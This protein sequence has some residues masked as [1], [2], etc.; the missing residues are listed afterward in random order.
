MSV[1]LPNGH[2]TEDTA[3]RTAHDWGRAQ[4]RPPRSATVSRKSYTVS[5]KLYYGRAIAC[6]I[7][8]MV[9]ACDGPTSTSSSSDPSS[10]PV[11]GMGA[12]TDESVRTEA[13]GVAYPFV[14]LEPTATATLSVGQQATFW[15]HLSE[16]NGNNWPS[17]CSTWV[18][19]DPS[20]AS[21]SVIGYGLLSGEHAVVVAHSRGRAT[22][23]ATTESQTTGTLTVT[24]GSA[25]GTSTSEGSTSGYTSSGSSS[26][27]GSKSVA[28][29]SASEPT[30]GT[31]EPA[32]MATQVNTGAL[33]STA[34]FS[35][36][37]SSSQSS[38]GAWSGNLTP[39]PGGTGLR[40]T[41]RTNLPAGSAPVTFGVGIRSPGTGWYYQRMNVRFSPNWT[42]AENPVIKL[43]EPQTQQHGSG[44]GPTENPVIGGFVN[45]GPTESYLTTLLQGPNGH[46]RDLFAEPT[47]NAQAN[48]SDGNWHTMEVLFGPESSPGAGNGTYKAWVD[49]VQ[50]ASDDNVLWL[51]PGNRVGWPYLL[52]QPVYGGVQSRPP[53]T[54]YWDFDELYVSTR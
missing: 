1:R 12:R 31:H 18:S 51:A 5:R 30:T 50:V 16:A 21:V 2:L 47:P 28:S 46:F 7:V 37:S 43:C 45:A 35:M 20:I 27:S 42:N 23:T 6:V 48:L 17:C 4:G 39:V 44:E 32:G 24:V 13:A 11:D 52:F 36:F 8:A 3:M 10:P 9:A 54:M 49:G 40:I 15:A 26:G 53:S 38:S 19:S 25:S 29:T 14:T 41:Y 33:T 22:I 34:P